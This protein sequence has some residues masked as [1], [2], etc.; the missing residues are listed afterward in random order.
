MSDLYPDTILDAYKNPQHKQDMTDADLVVDGSNSSCGD[1][2]IFYLKKEKSADTWQKI[3][4][5]G[6]GCAVSQ[7][8]IELLV[9][10]IAV[11]KL[12]KAEVLKLTQQDMQ[13]L[14]ELDQVSP[15]RQKCVMMGLVT[16][17]KAIK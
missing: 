14:L 11:E 13:V 10:K 16:L 1:D 4:W 7:A 5:Q 2:V 6:N 12:T 15:G 8:A 17:Q 9:E 3:T